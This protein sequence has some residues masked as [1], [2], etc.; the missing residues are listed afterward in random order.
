MPRNRQRQL[1]TGEFRLRAY[2]GIAAV[3]LVITMIWTMAHG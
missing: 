2:L 1:T 3:F